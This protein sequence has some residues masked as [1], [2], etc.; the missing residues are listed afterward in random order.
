MEYARESALE[1]GFCGSLPMPRGP[2][3]TI[4]ELEFYGQTRIQLNLWP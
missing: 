1:K 3:L 4:I 2:T